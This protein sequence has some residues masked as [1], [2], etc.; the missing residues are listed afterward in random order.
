MKKDLYNPPEWCDKEKVIATREGWYDI[1]TGT[2][3]A[4]VTGLRNVVPVHKIV[5]PL[6]K[7][8][9]KS[10]AKVKSKDKPVTKPKA[11]RKRKSKD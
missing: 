8:K 6:E 11:R 9:R 3:V 1:E 2:I 10:K 4:R 5:K 7:V